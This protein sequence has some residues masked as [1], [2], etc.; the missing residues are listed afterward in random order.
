MRER[1]ESYIAGSRPVFGEAVAN[2]TWHRR[3][4]NNAIAMLGP[5][6]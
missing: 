3:L 6:L 5:V 1:Q 4:L 2:W